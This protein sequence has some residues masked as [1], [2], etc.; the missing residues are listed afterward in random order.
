MGIKNFLLENPTKISQQTNT[1]FQI[2][3]YDPFNFNFQVSKKTIQQKLQNFCFVLQILGLGK[4]LSFWMLIQVD[5]EVC[6]CTRGIKYW[7]SSWVV[8]RV[9]V[10]KMVSIEWLQLGNISTGAS[11]CHLPGKMTREN[12]KNYVWLP[13]VFKY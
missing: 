11:S 10:S 8:A 13:L 1:K 7:L 12:K 5:L 3:L 2:I 9:S 4:P 6:Y